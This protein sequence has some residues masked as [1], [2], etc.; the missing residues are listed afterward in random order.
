MVP[1]FMFVWL[2]IIVVAIVV[3]AVFFR[4]VPL[5][6]WINARASGAPVKIVSLIGMRF[7]H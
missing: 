2:I 3:A 7:R 6:L 5:G 4:Y 1:D